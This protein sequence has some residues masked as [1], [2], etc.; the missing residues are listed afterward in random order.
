MD[1]GRREA[2]KAGGGASLLTLLVAAGWVTPAQAQADA[3]NKAAFEAKTLDEALK[4]FGG[5]AS[6]Q[7]KD[8]AFVATPDFRNNRSG[9]E[10]RRRHRP[11]FRHR[12]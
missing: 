12:R 10:R 1:A 11:A 8:I 9:H 3:W 5:G 4:A 2:L 6:A 7:S